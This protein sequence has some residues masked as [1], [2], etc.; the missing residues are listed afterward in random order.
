MK[1]K[2]LGNSPKSKPIS[3]KDKVL[4][5]ICY[6]CCPIIFSALIFHKKTNSKSC[7]IMPLDDCLQF[8]IKQ[9]LTKLG[10]I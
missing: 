10:L 6:I 8:L 2:A 5:L 4:D 7:I 9:L 3:K 1:I